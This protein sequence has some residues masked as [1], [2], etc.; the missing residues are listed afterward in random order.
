MRL[1]PPQGRMTRDAERA[2]RADLRTGRTD[3]S[4]L[5]VV[6]DALKLPL[7]RKELVPCGDNPRILDEVPLAPLPRIRL[8]Q[9][10]LLVQHAMKRRRELVQEV[11]VDREHDQ[12]DDALYEE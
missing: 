4:L 1:P 12:V 3:V 10:E 2:Q 11:L 5:E 9:A 7:Q 8:V 6:E